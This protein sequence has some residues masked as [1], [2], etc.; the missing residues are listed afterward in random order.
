ME[1][2]AQTS[3]PMDEDLVLDGGKSTGRCLYGEETVTCGRMDFGRDGA[4]NGDDWGE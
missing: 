2:I 1:V 4:V 3:Y